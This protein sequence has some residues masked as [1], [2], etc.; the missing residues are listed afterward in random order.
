MPSPIG[1][2][3]GSASIGPPDDPGEWATDQ[4]VAASIRIE[5]C[6]RTIEGLSRSVEQVRAR[7]GLGPGPSRRGRDDLPVDSRKDQFLVARQL[8]TTLDGVRL[9]NRR[10]SGLAEPLGA[11]AHELVRTTRR[12]RR[13]TSF[14]VAYDRRSGRTP[15]AAPEGI[16][17]LAFRQA[18]VALDELDRLEADFATW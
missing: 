3:S 1:S 5:K 16:E 6:G 7:R 2:R 18:P 15:I 10:L 4:A 9:L 11:E 17:S 14:G 12:R 13:S 8:E